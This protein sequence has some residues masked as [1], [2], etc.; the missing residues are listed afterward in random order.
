[1]NKK[2]SGEH[3]ENY[4]P[5]SKPLRPY[6]SPAILSRE[7]LESAANVCSGYGLKTQPGLPS[8]DGISLCGQT[9]THS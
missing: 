9:G 3:S 7:R 2:P 5:D 6:Q 4:D 1:M 8:G